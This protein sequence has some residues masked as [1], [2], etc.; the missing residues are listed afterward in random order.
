LRFPVFELAQDG[1]ALALLGRGGFL[2]IYFG[3]GQRI[4]LPDGER[5]RMRAMG[6]RGAICPVI[7]DSSGR[8]V[9]FAGVGNGAYGLNTTGAA[10]ILFPVERRHLSGA[11][12]WALGDR[13]EQIAEVTLS[14][15]SIDAHRPVPLG[16][17]FLCFALAR[18]GIPG[19][20]TPRLAAGGWGKV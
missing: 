16:M 11:N 1:E 9:A 2:K 13:T 19:E 5:W 18:Y 4:E 10:A 7:V 15:P 6:A 20:S 14:P 12:R 17:V 3:S 8:K